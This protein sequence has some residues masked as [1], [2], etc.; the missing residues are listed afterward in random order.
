MSTTAIVPEISPE[1][2]GTEF[3]K[4][5]VRQ[6]RAVDSYGNYDGWPTDRLL[7]PYIVTKEQRR[8][9]PVIGDPDDIILAR[10]KAYHNAIAALIEKECGLMA[11]PLINIT[12]EGFGRALITVGKLVVMDRTLRD[13][14]RFGFDSYSKMKD[15]CDKHLA[16]ALEIIGKY[17]E[18]AGL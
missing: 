12:H 15:D 17:P 5:M 1:L 3:I 14:H 16:V 10:V 9:I 8:E 18:V 6:T 11:V 4:E 2:A 13:V 7:A